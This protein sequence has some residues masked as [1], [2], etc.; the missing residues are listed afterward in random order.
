MDIL[1]K[2]IKKLSEDQ[3]QELIMQ[4]SGKKKNKPFI[5]LETARQRDVEDS[6]MMKMLQVNPSTYYT[7]KSRLNSKIAS[8]LSKK[9]SN[10]ISVL[11]EE[12]ARVPAN[13][14]GTNKEFSIRALKE[15]EKQLIEYDLSSELIIVYKTLSQ[16]HAYSD[17]YQYYDQLYN[18]HV[19]F[20]LSVS[21]AENL[22]YLF[23]K[24]IGIY[25]LTQ[26]QS[27]L[28]EVILIKREMK[29]ICELYQ[30]HRLFVIYNMMHIYYLCSVAGKREGLKARELEI[31]KIIK[32]M[33]VIF[34]KYSL[35]TFY[36]NIKCTTDFMFFEFYQ[37]TQNQVRA[38]FYLQQLTPAIPDITSRHAMCFY[39]VQMLNSKIEKFLTDGDADKLTD[40]N[41]HLEKY[42]DID[43]QEEYHFISYKKFLAVSR[44]YQK[45]YAGSARIINELRNVI[46][47][48][49]YLFTDVECKLFQALQYCIMGEDGLC[50]QIISSLKR[51]IREDETA[52]TSAHIFIKVLKTALKPADYRKKIKKINELWL[53]FN[54]ANKVETPILRFLRLDENIIR[55]MT[56]PIKE[57]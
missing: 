45:D 40:M 14:Y 5:V 1:N 33:N 27:D 39:I 50:L 31:E 24:K 30:S 4:V 20:S 35:D 32:E 57:S 48:K 9:V 36:Q 54:L 51:Q 18:K 34:E 22:Y 17:D 26:D 38:D 37:K 19:A 6:E 29:N 46:S 55:R 47:L 25:L 21:K 16:L 41:G 2:T 42:F 13:L 23:G 7:L 56:N 52:F 44:F 3:Y 12:V 53:E 49:Q 15:L 11:M 10:P 43:P 8:I 28:E